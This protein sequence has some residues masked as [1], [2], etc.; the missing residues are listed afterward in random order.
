MTH[1]RLISGIRGTGRPLRWAVIGSSVSPTGF[2]ALFFD[3]VFSSM[4]DAFSHSRGGHLG[5]TTA[6]W[7]DEAFWIGIFRG[8]LACHLP[9]DALGSIGFFRCHLLLPSDEV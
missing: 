9:L 4:P 3:N 8:V 6:R 7:P 1:A 5:V 2:L